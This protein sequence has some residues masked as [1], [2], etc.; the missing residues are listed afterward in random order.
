MKKI[1]LLLLA[2]IFP[3]FSYSEHIIGGDFT[4][5]HVEGNTFQAI[6]TLFR[7]CASG[8]APFDP[9]VDV[10]VFDNVTNEQISELNFTFT[11]F[12]AFE[13]DLGNSCFT[14]DICMEIGTYE[15]EFTLDDNP[16]GYYLSK[17]RCCRN[18]LSINLQGTDLGFV[19]TLDVPDPALENSS[20]MFG[21][22]PTEAFFC[23]NGETQIDFGAT[24]ADG[25][26]LVYSFTEPL[27]GESTALAPNPIIASPKP[28]S[29]VE[30]APG[31]STDDQVGGNTPM[32]INPET[33]LIIAQP[34]LVGVFTIAVKVEE[35]RDGVKIGEI[36]RELQLASSVCAIDVPS[37]IS[38]PDNDT[39]FDVLANTELCFD[40]TATD[41]NEGDTL[42]LFAEG[43]LFDGT[44]L[45][46]AS[47]PPSDSISEVTQTF[48][49]APL[50]SNLSDE[51]YVITVS[52]FSVGCSPD[53][54]I[55]TQDLYFNVFVEPDEPTEYVGPPDGYTIDLYDPSTYSFDIEFED[56]NEAD[57][58]TVLEIQSEIFDSGNVEPIEPITD[59]GQLNLPLT[60][61]VTCED[62]RDEPYFIDFILVTT[63]CDVLDTTQFSVP[64]NV[65]VQPNEPTQFVEPPQEIF[66]EFYSNDS[67]IIPVTVADG[68]YF[69][70]LVVSAASEIFGLPGNP[71][72][73]STLEGTSLVEGDL[74]WV[75]NCE[76]VR[77]EPYQ[78]IFTATANSCKTDDVVQYPIDI[79]LTLPP[80]NQATITMPADGTFIEHF[81]GQD[82][83]EILVVGNDPDPYDTLSLEIAGNV[84]EAPVSTPVFETTGFIENIFGE[85]F[86]APNCG[87]VRD[88]PYDLTFI[89]RSRSCQ[90][91]ETVEVNLDVLLTTPTRGVIEPIQN[92]FT[93][94]EDGF[95]DTWT[96]ENKDDP[97]LLDFKAQVF[98][99]WG[100]EVYISRDP[101]F[102]W[103]GESITSEEL[104]G[105]TYFR[106]IEYTYK[107]SRQTY[108]G[109][110][111]ILK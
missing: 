13:A 60:W 4:V 14:P 77:E 48:C 81:I 42:F 74:I 85:F 105:G 96:I 2:A 100:K 78:V 53:T 19:F 34:D 43:E 102:E 88:D 21:E 55:T 25:D 29:E 104:L 70:T 58:L 8:G 39:V 45:P 1:L 27:N 17:E 44:V 67:L 106:T 68:N 16:N 79:F 80:E 62:V 20:P 33:G 40:I 51:P 95:N 109:T 101:N 54:L 36:R 3:F 65:I 26:S 103:N 64:I 18:N 52:A 98:D 12:D 89:L 28:Y 47:F 66:F 24:D 61:I 76:D 23:V 31:Y 93:P 97:C 84:F 69:D 110:I 46:L 107:L 71:A 111:D 87:D 41:P 10:T 30:W 37:V 35:F 91:N 90:K 49:W 99:R 32:S 50:C 57:S 86:W 9:T 38:T 6:L 15:T 22:F 108:S 56:P 63:N 5:Q 82:P 11:G 75:P 83:I 7:D 59:Q 92:V 73:F 94:N 72:V